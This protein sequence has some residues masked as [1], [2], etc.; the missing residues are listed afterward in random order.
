MDKVRPKL[1]SSLT[2]GDVKEEELF[3]NMVLRP[4]IKM[5]HDI[6]ILRV[7]SYFTSKKVIFHLMDTRKRTMAIEQ[8]FLGDNAFKKE[9]QGM[10]TGQLAPD[11]FKTYLRWERSINKRIVQM[12]RN[13]M[14]DSLLALS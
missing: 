13:R 10:I 7:R 8:A 1:P 14:I 5:Q 4:V 6:L 11:E 3:Q 2:E 9:I 12:V